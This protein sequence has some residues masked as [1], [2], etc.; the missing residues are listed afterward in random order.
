MLKDTSN[1]TTHYF[2]DG[3]Q[4]PHDN[5]SDKPVHKSRGFFDVGTSSN[6]AHNDIPSNAKRTGDAG[7]I[8]VSTTSEWTEDFY[9]IC[10]NEDGQF[11]P[12]L[13]VFI[14]SL[15]SRKA[16]ELKEAVRGMKRDRDHENIPHAME[17]RLTDYQN[18]Y[19]T[20]LSAVEKII[21]KIMR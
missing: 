10:R 17:G 20:A 13:M 2:G 16:D 15:L 19:D 14:R 7:R 21:E 9:E 6:G 12:R 4:P 11:R 18:G 8:A 1:G 3:C 5:P